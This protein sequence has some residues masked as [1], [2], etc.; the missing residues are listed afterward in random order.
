[1]TN[2]FNF[3]DQLVLSTG[4]TVNTAIGEILTDVIPGSLRAFRATQEED[5]QGI[6]WWVETR[7]GE[8]VGVDC[9]VRTKDLWPKQDDLALE[10]WSVVE[11]KI[12]GWSLDTSKRTDYIFWIWTD[13]GRWCIVPFLLLVRAFKAKKDAWALVFPVARQSTEGRYHSECIFVSRRE[14]WAEIYRQA[15]G[16]HADL[17]SQT[18]KQMSLFTGDA[19]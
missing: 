12:V 19:A 11:K 17:E 18:E 14:L 2:T 1:M 13:T 8:R 9:K 4:T 6:D 3:R 16:R 7:S 10:T 5:R 15:Q